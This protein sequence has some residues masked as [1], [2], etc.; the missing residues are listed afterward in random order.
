MNETNRVTKKSSGLVRQETVAKKSAIKNVAP[1]VSKAKK[2]GKVL[3][4]GSMNSLLNQGSRP[5]TNLSTSMVGSPTNEKE[6]SPS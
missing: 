4:K 5:V 6:E 1:T 2:S 3:R